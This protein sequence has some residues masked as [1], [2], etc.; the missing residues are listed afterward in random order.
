MSIIFHIMKEEYDRLCE[1]EH[2][3][4]KS[5]LDAAQGAPRIKRIGNKDY[6]YLERRKGKKVV[7]DYIGHA[8]GPKAAEVLAAVKRRNKDRDSLRRILDDL[9]DVKKV[10]R[11]KI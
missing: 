8:D 6:L 1:A 2:A 11:G 9:K 5:V 3:Y 10:L 7:Y 4:R